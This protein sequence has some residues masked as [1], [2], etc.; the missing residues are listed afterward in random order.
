[1]ELVARVRAGELDAFEAIMRRNNQ[2]LFRAARAILKNDDEA[3]DVLQ[4]AYVQAFAHLD[5][6]EGRARLS[7][8]LT[9]IVVHE[10]YRRIRKKKEVLMDAL[11]DGAEDGGDPEQIVSTRE[12]AHVLEG[13]LD[14]L[15]EAFRTVFVLRMVERLDVA[16]TSAC[17]EIPEETVKTRLHRARQ[18][19]RSELLRQTD[20]ALTEVHR[21][22]GSRCDRVVAGVLARMRDGALQ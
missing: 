3:E 22:L 15:P 11:D 1:M 17:L 6:F 7:T 14:N 4:E 12:L 5:G 20:G 2:R 21:F 13:A 19:I 10:A 8:W 9:R 16:E 18:L